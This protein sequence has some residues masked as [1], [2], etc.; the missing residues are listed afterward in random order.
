MAKPDF[1][2]D[3]ADEDK[4]YPFKADEFGKLE[5]PENVLQAKL[6]SLND[7]NS[8]GRGAYPRGYQAPG[9]GSDAGNYYLFTMEE[10]DY[11]TIYKIK[12]YMTSGSQVIQNFKMAKKTS[13][14]LE[15]PVQS[16]EWIGSQP[17][18]Y[19]QSYGSAK[20]FEGGLRPSFM[21]TYT[22]QP[23][24]DFFDERGQL[25]H[26]LDVSVIFENYESLELLNLGHIHL[27]RLNWS[28]RLNVQ[29][30]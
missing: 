12:A 21:V 10:N 18:Q 23:L 29:P 27:P 19:A 28:C 13:I 3:Q 17:P 25:L 1:I 6:V 14:L 15:H 5:L 20:D 8:G 24:I 9:T 7:G 11:L 26:R 2:A 22:G 30:P 16:I 4:V